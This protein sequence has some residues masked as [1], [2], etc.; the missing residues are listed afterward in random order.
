MRLKATKDIKTIL[1]KQY[2]ST[3]EDQLRMLGSG[4]KEIESIDYPILNYGVTVLPIWFH[5]I[6]I[7]SH[8][9]SKPFRFMMKPANVPIGSLKSL[10]IT[11]VMANKFLY[12][13]EPDLSHQVLV[14]QGA[15]GKLENRDGCLDNPT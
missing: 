15:R 8:S 2:N 10:I 5:T 1:V 4:A 12:E 3:Y 6:P 7:H 9:D 14:S 11:T 13:S